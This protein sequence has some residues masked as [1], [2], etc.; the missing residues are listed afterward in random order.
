MD[1]HNLLD[2]E[3]VE[4]LVDGQVALRYG[5]GRLLEGTRRLEIRQHEV[6]HRYAASR[7]HL[8]RWSA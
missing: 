7:Q 3:L 5:S 8:R 4:E 2:E 1:F 6:T